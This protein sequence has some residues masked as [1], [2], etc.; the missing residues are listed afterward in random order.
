[1]TLVP[2]KVLSV[3]LDPANN[4]PLVILGESG[5]GRALPIWIG[6]PE[7]LSINLA[8]E[9]VAL[10]RPLTHD[11]VKSLLEGLQATV[12]RIVITELKG[13]T[14]FAQIM[15]RSGDR[16]LAVDARPS[17][18]I[19]IALRTS[20]PI[21]VDDVVLGEHGFSR[22]DGGEDDLAERLKRIKPEDF[23]KFTL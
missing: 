5:G 14:F 18:S 20:S 4:T 13:S 2:V 23:G 9:G 8:L 16:L 10:E 3:G 12:E 11:L 1:M 21:F 15:L 6:S 22:T 7:A 17:D 19:A